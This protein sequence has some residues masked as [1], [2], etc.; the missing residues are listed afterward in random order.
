MVKSIQRITKLSKFLQF[1]IIF[2]I[3]PINVK[4]QNKTVSFKFLSMTTVAFVMMLVLISLINI[5]PSFLIVDMKKIWTTT[6]A[7]MRE[8]KL[9]DLL[10]FVSTFGM[11]HL[12]PI[13]P[14][15]VARGCQWMP[16]EVL[17][18][19]DLTWPKH[20]LMFIFSIASLFLV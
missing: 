3:L 7:E 4:K 5:T 2:K 11:F 19:S 20:G 17:L 14:L 15:V 12:Y 6:V 18:A 13:F 16:T 8:M 9:T 1:L 10:C